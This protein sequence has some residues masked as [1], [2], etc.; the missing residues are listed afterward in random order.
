MI[1]LKKIKAREDADWKAGT[2]SAKWV[3]EGHE[4]IQVYE[5][6]GQWVAYDEQ[7]DKILFRKWEKKKIRES[8]T[9]MFAEAE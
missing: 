1:R 9:E 4:H 5:W 6:I 2:T 3:V 7:T 8:L